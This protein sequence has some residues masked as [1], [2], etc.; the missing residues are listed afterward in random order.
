MN[1]L[2]IIHQTPPMNHPPPPYHPPL[3]QPATLIRVDTCDTLNH[4]F[5]ETHTATAQHLRGRRWLHTSATAHWTQFTA[6]WTYTFS[7]KERDPETGLSYFG[8]RYYSSDLSI[9]LSVDPMSAKYPSLSPYT[10]CA[11]NPVRCVDPNG[12]EIEYNSFVDR[13]I[14]GLTRVFNST[15]NAHF[16]ELRKSQETYVFKKNDEGKNNFTTNGDK[17]FINYSTNDN[18]KS[19]QAGQTIFSHLRHETT[20]GIQFEH[21]E[22]GFQLKGVG[23]GILDRDD[24]YF[25]MMTWQPVN[26]D[27]TDEYEAHTNQN[28]GFRMSSNY[29]SSQSQWN[30]ASESERYNALSQIPQYQSLERNPINNTNTERIKSFTLYA[31]PNTPRTSKTR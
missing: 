20:H 23:W 22:I 11:N 12:E 17:L 13:L 27:L 4:T 24:N 30:R 29:S 15:F 19:R 21:G 14:V 16:K 10:Y 28:L 1:L 9:W 18:G 8:S 2:T 31:R 3:P 25:E 5:R 7:A 6:Y 26:Y